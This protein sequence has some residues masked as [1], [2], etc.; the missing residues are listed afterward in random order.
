[1]TEDEIKQLEEITIRGIED[2]PDLF[3]ELAEL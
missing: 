3:D 2:N 1:M